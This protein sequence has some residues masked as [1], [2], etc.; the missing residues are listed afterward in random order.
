MNKLLLLLLLMIVCTSTILASP[1]YTKSE[2]FTKFLKTIDSE[3]PAAEHR[4]IILLAEDC[5]RRV[6]FNISFI[7]QFAGAENTTLIISYKYKL[8]NEDLK[9]LSKSFPTIMDSKGSFAK[10]N[11]SPFNSCLIITENKNI[12]EIIKFHKMD[13]GKQKLI[14]SRFVKP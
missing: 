1:I 4:F 5:G 9:E 7:K 10:Y 13:K 2:L 14:K 8:R 6:D 11:I 12:K 3:V